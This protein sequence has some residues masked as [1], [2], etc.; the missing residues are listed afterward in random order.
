[1]E[2][3]FNPLYELTSHLCYVTV[4]NSFFDRFVSGIRA[5]FK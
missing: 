5:V 1:M 3:S 4:M 2:N